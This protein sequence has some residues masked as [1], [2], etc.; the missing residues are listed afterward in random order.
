MKKGF[1]LIELLVVIG[2][3]GLLS[4]L[5]V[6]SFGNI[7]EKARD[8]KRLADMDALQKA[9]AIM[10]E[11]EGSYTVAGVSNITKLVLSGARAVFNAGCEF[12][13]VSNCSGKLLEY[14][15][16]L[17]KLNDPSSPDSGCVAINCGEVCNYQFG[18]LEKDHYEVYFF[19][20]NGS[21]QYSDRGCYQISESGIE[22]KVI[23][24]D[25]Q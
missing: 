2:I 18:V 15:P 10:Y 12:G 5:A 1:T 17:E 4:S 22:K 11:N 8:V 3:L 20:E 9:M 7:R 13:S 6:V 23:N 24:V 21:S 25:V 19:L 14:L 16:G